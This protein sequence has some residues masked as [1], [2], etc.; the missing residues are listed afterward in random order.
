VNVRSSEDLFVFGKRCL[1]LLPFFAPVFLVILTGAS[2]RGDDVAIHEFLASNTG[3]LEDEDGESPDWIEV[4]NPGADPVDLENWALT[5]DPAHEDLWV[6][7]ARVLA[8]G[9]LLV[10]FASGKDRRSGPELHTG[11]RLARSGE[12]LA[13]LQPPS[14]PGEPREAAERFSGAYPR[15]RT[16]VSFGFDDDGIVAYFESPTPGE[17]NGEAFEGFVADTS[18]SV[19]RGFY[20]DA[21]DLAISSRTEGARIR[22]T[23]DGSTPTAERGLLYE[24]PISIDSTTIVRA[25]AFKTDFVPTN[26]DSHTYLFLDDVVRQD[27]AG[28]PTLWNDARADYEMDP[29]IVDSPA[30]RDSILDDLRDLPTVSIATE[31]DDLFGPDGIY[32]NP[33]QG[34]SGWERPASIEYLRNDGVE[35]FQVEAGVQIAGGASRDWPN[36][37]KKSFRI[38]FKSRY[39]PTR[40]EYPL[41]DDSDVTRFN[42]IVLRAGYNYGWLH[43]YADQRTRAQYMRDQFARETQRDLGQ[44]TSHGR[45]VHLYLDGLYWGIYNLIERADGA[46]AASYLGGEEDDYDSIKGDEPPAA[47]SGDTDFWREMFSVAN[48]GVSTPAGY[49]RIQEYLDPDSL[50]V[51]SMVNHYIGNIDGPVCICGDHRPRNFYAARRRTDEGR[52]HFF[53]W[54]SEHSLS[55][56]NVDRSDL[57]VTNADNTPARLYGRLRANAEFRMRFADH[58]HRAYFNDGPLSPQA[59]IARWEGI[60]RK[61]DRAVVAESARWGDTRRAEPYTRDVEWVA[62]KARLVDRFFPVRSSVV[63]AQ[64]R[65]DGLYPSVAAPTLSQHGGLVPRDFELGMIAAGGT[66][67]YSL[68]GADPRLPGGELSPDTIAYGPTERNILIG[69]GAATR[70]VVPSSDALGLDWADP[71]FDDADWIEGSTGVGYETGNGYE[72]LIA[73]DLESEMDDVN[74]SAFI[75][76]PFDLGK[77][78]AVDA[79]TLRMK[80]DDGFIAYLNGLEVARRNAPADAGWNANATA[81]HSDARAVVFEDIDIPTALNVLRP[82]RNVLAIHGLNRT[83][84]S[85]DFLIL[86]ELVALSSGDSRVEISRSVVVKARAL[87]DGEWSAVNEATFVLDEPSPLRLTEIHYHPTPPTPGEPY[88]SDDFE[89]LELRNVGTEP[90]GLVGV[91]ILG[92][93][94][95]DFSTSAVALLDPGEHLVIVEN[96]EAF[97]SRYDVSEMTIAGEYS[98]KLDN[99]EGLVR[100]VDARGET[101]LEVTYD[102]TW[103]SET[104]GEGRSLVIVDDEAPPESWSDAASWRSSARDSGSPGEFDKPS[105]LG[106]GQLPGDVNQDGSAD[107]S[108]AVTLLRFLFLGSPPRLPCGDGSPTDEGNRTLANPNGDGAIDLTD[109]IYI[110]EYFFQGGTPPVQGAECRPVE[111]CPEVC[112]L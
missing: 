83:S 60:A 99:D 49:E 9:E 77:V 51:Y 26:V 97:A 95:F 37:M 72:D 91:R 46:F 27:G 92:E 50:I 20:D 14:S 44:L 4:R 78:G 12:Y 8:P 73:T 23:L 15:Q 75:R 71:D 69:E 87:D 80:Y 7:P 89:F 108:D 101:V 10:V 33:T 1:A 98:G 22:Y 67:Y 28:F 86:P 107:I 70:V 39:G 58:V 30:Y 55:E 45:Y 93:V 41:F 96:L 64:H 42:T 105:D 18:F 112:T 21:F 102:D 74:A 103:S 65:A 47:I 110:L 111:G 13:L 84:S 3:G 54:D 62:E 59:T 57:G 6:F 25:I 48:A 106:G 94:E 100:L 76:V 36:S 29:E 2:A 52:Y 66:V 68:D 17:P 16:N 63:L 79:L 109:A 40:L 35:G 88:S 90:V 85:S 11:F 34:G 24:S 19:D 81:S 104:D 53:L 82:G 38:V 5:D 31:P 61:I 56:T 43:R 32:A